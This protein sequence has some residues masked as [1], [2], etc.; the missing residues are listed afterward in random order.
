VAKYRHL[1]GNP[2][3]K[4]PIALGSDMACYRLLSFSVMTR[5]GCVLLLVAA[6]AFLASSGACW[7]S[8]PSCG[9]SPRIVGAFGAENTP[10]AP[11]ELSADVRSQLPGVKW[12]DE[13]LSTTLAP[14]GEQVIIYSSDDDESDPHPKVAFI[15]GG[16]L[17][18]VLDASEIVP[19]AGGFWRYLSG[20]QFEATRHQKALAL[21]FS[22]TFDGSGSAFAVI[23]WQSGKYQIVFNP[24][25]MQGRIVLSSGKLALWASDGMG[26]CVWCGQHYQISR[27]LWHDRTYVRTSVIKLKQ[28]YDPA[29]ISGIP[30]VVASH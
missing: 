2:G 9:G 22:T 18:K 10:R 28:A 11:L 23:M 6:S 8:I 21:A 27:Y 24:F 30:L 29:T 17:G 7:A 25:V 15:I 13:L 16:K 5:T 26:Q 1:V 12:V 3:R 14:S 20:C 4:A 19:K